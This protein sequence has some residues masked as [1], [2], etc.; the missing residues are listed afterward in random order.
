MRVTDD[1]EYE[2][3]EEEKSKV[4]KSLIKKPPDTPTKIDAKEF[5]EL[6]DKE[7]VNYFENTAFF[8][9]LLKC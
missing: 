1:Y 4:I 6:I 9:D 2:S 5:N 8:K 7:T 3:E